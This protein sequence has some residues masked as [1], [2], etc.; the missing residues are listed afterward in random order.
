[1]QGQGIRARIYVIPSWMVP[2]LDRS[3]IQHQR[4]KGLLPLPE[5][6]ANELAKAMNGGVHQRAI[7]RGG[8]FGNEASFG[9]KRG[10]K[11]PGINADKAADLAVAYE[12]HVMR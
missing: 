8:S 5:S 4:A 1:V 9:N 3:I 6:W 10:E 12:Y 11:D 7:C 2:A